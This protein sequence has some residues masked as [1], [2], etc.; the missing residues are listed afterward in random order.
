[1]K[2]KRPLATFYQHKRYLL[3]GLISQHAYL[4]IDNSVVESADAI[5]SSSLSN[6]FR[7]SMLSVLWDSVIAGR[8]A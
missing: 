7:Q 2:I 8:R 5:I 3:V 4:E 1:M 6:I